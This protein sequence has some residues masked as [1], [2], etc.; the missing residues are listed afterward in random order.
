MMAG[1]TGFLM[2][3]GAVVGLLI[4]AVYVVDGRDRVAR[5]RKPETSYAGG[6]YA[7]RARVGAVECQQRPRPLTYCRYFPAGDS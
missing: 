4:V 7:D 5:R 3:A 2:L 6:Y 1:V